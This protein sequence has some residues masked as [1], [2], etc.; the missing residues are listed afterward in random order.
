MAYGAVWHDITWKRQSLASWYASIL[1][2]LNTF[3]VF[4]IFVLCISFSAH[5]NYIFGKCFHTIQR[6]YGVALLRL[7]VMSETKM[8][9]RVTD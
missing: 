2:T 1:Y 8:Q 4:G 3:R 7:Y 9:V 6:I 5:I